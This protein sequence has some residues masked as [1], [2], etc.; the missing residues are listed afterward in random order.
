[1]QSEV[2]PR[3]RVGTEAAQTACT[4]RGSS[5]SWGLRPRAKRTWNIRTMFVTLDVSKR[6]GWLNADAPCRVET[7]RACAAGRGAARDA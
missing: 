5:Q 3:R 6:N 4:G 1:M 7:R 2:R